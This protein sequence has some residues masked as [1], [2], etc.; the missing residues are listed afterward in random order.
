MRGN[1]RSCLYNDHIRRFSLVDPTPVVA[2]CLN[3]EEWV[4]P[5]HPA[6]TTHRKLAEVVLD[7]I[8]ALDGKR[9]RDN[10]DQ[11][12]QDGRRKDLQP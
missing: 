2:G 6:A 4:D 5:V 8:R 9:K 12:S 1:L 3:K 10:E 11:S 7:S